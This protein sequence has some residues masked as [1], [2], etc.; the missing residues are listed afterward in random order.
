MNSTSLDLKMK[1]VIMECSTPVTSL[2]WIPMEC[3]IA[4]G[5]LQKVLG[6]ITV[7]G[8]YEFVI[9]Y[10]QDG[11][12]SLGRFK[13]CWSHFT[14]HFCIPFT[15][16]NLGYRIARKAHAQLNQPVNEV[17]AWYRS[18]VK[19]DPWCYDSFTSYPLFS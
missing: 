2:S 8:G 7:A 13:Q 15:R 6:G 16:D 14:S 10:I 5:I 11:S 1:D 12:F 3:N 17:A 9:Y 19:C 18:A 4:A